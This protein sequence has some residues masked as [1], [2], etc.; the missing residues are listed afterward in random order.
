MVAAQGKVGLYRRQEETRLTLQPLLLQ[1]LV[2]PVGAPEGIAFAFGSPAVIASVR[3]RPV[4][5]RPTVSRGLP[6]SEQ[7]VYSAICSAS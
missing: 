5:L 2:L 6:L 7:L 3:R 4:A 1:T